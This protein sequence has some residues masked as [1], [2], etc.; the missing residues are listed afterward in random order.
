MC[1][2]AHAWRAVR[3]PCRDGGSTLP[4]E[5][6]TPSEAH[7]MLRE[8]VD[9]VDRL[10]A[11]ASSEGADVAARSSDGQPSRSSNPRS[12]VY[13]QPSQ[14]TRN[15]LMLEALRQ[16]LSV[17]NIHDLL[18]KIGCLALDPRNAS[19]AISLDALAHLIS[20]LPHDSQA[21][22]ISWRRLDS[23]I[24]EHLGEES[25]PGKADDPA[26]QMFTQE[27]IF[28]GGSAVVFP[29]AFVGNA[30]IVRWLMK[31]ALLKHPP[32][33]SSSFREAI[34]S[35][36][37]LCLATSDRIS[38]RAGLSRGVSPV[39]IDD[40]NIVMPMPG[41][42]LRLA[43]AVK[44]SQSDLAHILQSE[45]DLHQTLAPL[46]ISDGTTVWEGYSVRFGELHH[47]PFVKIQEEY[48]VPIPSALLNA[49]RHRMLCIAREHDVVEDLLAA[50]TELLQAEIETTLRYQHMHHIPFALPYP[51]PT[52]FSE[53]I[54][55]LDADKVVYLQ[56]VVDRLDGF[57]GLYE[58]ATWDIAPIG[59][60]LWRR[61]VQIVEHFQG[62]SKRVLTLTVVQ[63][64]GRIIA[65]GFN[66]P[67]GDSLHLALSASDLQAL[68]LSDN[69][70]VLSLWKF[71]RDYHAIRNKTQVLAMDLLDEYALYS[72]RGHSYYFFDDR[73]PALLYVQVGEGLSVRKAVSD[74]LDPH[75]VSSFIS[76]YVA[77]V[78]SV[79]GDNVP[80]AA[81]PFPI[82]NRFA[83]VVEG[84]LPIP[85]WVIL[86]YHVEP[87]LADF[88]KRIL[89]TIAYWLWQFESFLKRLI[90]QSSS[91]HEVFAIEI[92]F[93]N[94]PQWEAVL[95]DPAAIDSSDTQIL[96][97]L[98]RTM[99][100]MRVSIHASLLPHLAG[101]TN[102]G[103][104]ELMAALF[105]AFVEVLSTGHARGEQVLS[106]NELASAID[107]H[108]PLG[109]KKKLILLPDNPLLNGDRSQLPRFRA[110][111]EQ[112]IEG[113]LDWVGANVM[114][115]TN[116]PAPDL[117][118]AQKTK[119]INEAVNH[120]YVEL[121]R[122]VATLNREQL[123]VTLI[124]Y[125]ETNIS[126]TELSRITTPTH[127][128]CFDD[129]AGLI[130]EWIELSGS[131]T[132]ANAANRFL[133]EYVAASPSRGSQSLSLEIYDYLLAISNLICNWGMLSDFVA[134][135]L[136]DIGV[137]H[138]PSGRI[139]FDRANFETARGRFMAM[140]AHAAVLANREAFSSLWKSSVSERDGNTT[141]PEVLE[142]D[143]AMK[144]EF[145]LSLSEIVD[146]LLSVHQIGTQL[147]GGFRQLALEEFIDAL[148]E[149]LQWD[150]GKIQH[151]YKLF[152]IEP[153]N[154]FFN[155]PGGGPLEVFPWRFNREWSHLRRPILC[156]AAEGKEVILWGNRQIIS[157]LNYIVD[158]SLG[159][160]LKAK[161][162][163]LK[164]LISRRRD[165]AA[166]AFEKTVA[167]VL[168]Q[169]TRMLVKSR[170]M[171]I[172]K[173]RLAE[174]G[175][176][177]GDIDV[178]CAIPS[179]RILMCV[180]CKRLAFARTPSEIQHQMEALIIESSVDPSTVQKH[181][182][183][184]AW[185]ENHIDD[186]L[187]ECF[188]IFRKGGWQVKPVLISDSELFAP[189][190]REI[191]FGVWSLQTVEDM[192]VQDIVMQLQGG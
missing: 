60:R 125:N 118:T 100:G 120:F 43:D 57:V 5:D 112:D 145:D 28:P 99:L 31:A 46:A 33:G 18:K 159:G 24:Q 21:P 17:F 160:R 192:T 73:L 49:L 168:A 25:E 78:W 138:L 167:E 162:L 70:D 123:I 175:N 77:E 188:G 47:R 134:F 82:E 185:I 161:S 124:A 85:M 80:I 65:L 27:L 67:P 72:A 95:L 174:N 30:E 121:Q 104:R 108:A 34:S 119:V 115:P 92:E 152:A 63:S 146:F 50:Y 137:T 101:P 154:D 61:N 94:P 9:S 56:L 183:R 62:L 147:D 186:V 98:E 75:G 131:Q 19:R 79:F 89:E 153:R 2:A 176:D 166:K 144:S 148:V 139:G 158:S 156:F 71:A 178:L 44:F 86:P 13:S 129:R 149:L 105:R 151:A 81:P 66:K 64:V 136:A 39:D 23:L 22:S 40:R 84:Q 83:L 111:Q 68:V 8:V 1:W 54:F 187:K 130:E 87:H 140:Y 182:R 110:I 88:A 171:K 48:V 116:Q 14:A 12:P 189:H 135:G 143:R 170:V 35:T 52:E 103:E 150:T 55:S 38:Q 45:Q 106:G 4:T 179:A 102:Y 51:S 36:A 29:G 15:S 6:Q 114:F 157:S 164:Q 96:T 128:A 3:E 26:A 10:M 97:L 76:G 20:S 41:Q 16:S 132:N 173:T 133:I 141:P 180:E 91:T 172:G 165:E 113:L 190:L 127:F 11:L 74:R 69:T 93:D 7:P 42:A 177:L 117:T 107:T 109:L 163:P 191:P 90:Q 142:F 181:L 122:V 58:P 126:E 32:I 59:Q 169:K 37:A 155:P 53:G 184:T